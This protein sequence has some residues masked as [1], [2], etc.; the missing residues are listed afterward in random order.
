MEDVRHPSVQPSETLGY[1]LRHK[2]QHVDLHG[3]LFVYDV[4][5]HWR[6]KVGARDGPG[7]TPEQRPAVPS[8]TNADAEK[9]Q[10][11]TNPPFSISLP[12]RCPTLCREAYEVRAGLERRERVEVHVRPLRQPAAR[13]FSAW[14]LHSP[15]FVQGCS[16]VL[17]HPAARPNYCWRCEEVKAGVDQRARKLRLAWLFVHFSICQTFNS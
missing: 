12:H 4:T 10:R 1:R 11:T 14:N 17:S 15:K 9:R 6:Q 13:Q 2:V 7:V 16:A 5:R 8:A 3:S